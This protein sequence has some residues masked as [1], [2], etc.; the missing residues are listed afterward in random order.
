MF[1]SK[2]L[3]SFST[4]SLLSLLTLASCGPSQPT[5]QQT[6]EASSQASS[7]QTS[8]EA[9]PVAEPIPTQRGLDEIAKL[10]A[11][12]KAAVQDNDYETAQALFADVQGLWKKIEKGVNEKYPVSYRV[13]GDHLDTVSREFE[14]DPPNSA[15]V[16][17]T[18]NL[19]EGDVAEVSQ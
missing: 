15:D 7:K 1:S 13:I 14:Q 5:T 11:D 3:F 16:V 9:D 4:A 17:D 2:R 18:L 19:L 10:V 8:K 6:P 12:V